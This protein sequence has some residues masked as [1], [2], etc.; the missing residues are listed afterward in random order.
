MKSSQALLCFV[1]FFSAL[2]AAEQFSEQEFMSYFPEGNSFPSLN[3]LE[4]SMA[5]LSKFGFPYQKQMDAGKAD[6][7]RLSAKDQKRFLFGAQ[8]YGRYLRAYYKA[9]Y[10][11]TFANK[12][13]LAAAKA[14]YAKVKSGFPSQRNLIDRAEVYGTAQGFYKGMKKVA[15]ARFVATIA[16]AK[17]YK[18]MKSSTPYNAK[19]MKKEYF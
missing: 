6:F 3:S 5:Q 17:A 14:F 4:I 13:A 9:K 2:A 7:D 8:I 16:V 19:H 12:A 1:L 10:F 18:K 15:A 11:P